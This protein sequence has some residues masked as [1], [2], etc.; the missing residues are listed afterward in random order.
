[1]KVD[2]P[3]RT[4][5]SSTTQ[6]KSGVSGSGGSFGDLLTGGTSGPS[7]A[8]ATH[9]IAH[10]DA[11][12]AAQEAEDPTERAAR[13]RV[14]QRADSILN[15]LELMRRGLLMGTLTIGHLIDIADVVAQHR[16]KV[17]DPKMTAILDEIDLRAQIE[18][19]KLRKAMEQ[20]GR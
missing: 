16:D 19:A 9:A 17:L 10:I 8:G 12:L 11:L 1:M 2:G 15:E 18:L 20:H 13:R 14:V 4:Q 6:K 7:G 5:Q 3:N